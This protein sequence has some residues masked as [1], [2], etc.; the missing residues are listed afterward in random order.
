MIHIY[1][2][3]SNRGDINISNDYQQSRN[4]LYLPPPHLNINQDFYSA[5]KHIFIDFHI[6]YQVIDTVKVLINT[7]FINK[8]INN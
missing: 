4:I 8:K 3:V 1:I 6:Y 5:L 2:R 7:S